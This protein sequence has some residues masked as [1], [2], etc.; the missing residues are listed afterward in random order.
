MV[1][2]DI[3]ATGICVV[4]GKTVAVASLYEGS[5]SVIKLIGSPKILVSFINGY[6]E[7]EL[8]DLVIW[9]ARINLVS[10]SIDS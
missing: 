4:L 1:S 9:N 10:E 5:L 8:L 6:A 3:G 2:L 7:S